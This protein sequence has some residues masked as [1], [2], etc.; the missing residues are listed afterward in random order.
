[1]GSRLQL[2]T[3]LT[4]LLGSSAVYFQPPESVK[5]SYPCIVYERSDIRVDHANN[6]PYSMRKEYSLTI[7][8]RDPDSDIPERAM[9]L[10]SA[11]HE[12]AFVTDGLNH[13]IITIF[14]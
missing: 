14:F 6:K 12:R 4:D 8:T 9:Q 13:T 10:E 2:H 5:L 3:I 11:R 1:M 7:M